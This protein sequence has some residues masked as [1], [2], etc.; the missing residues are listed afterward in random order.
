M[1]ASIEGEASKQVSSDEPAH[2]REHNTRSRDIEQARK[3]LRER[4][5][6][7]V[8]SSKQEIIASKRNNKQTS[9]KQLVDQQQARS[10]P[11][12]TG[13]GYGNSGFRLRLGWISAM[14]TQGPY[15]RAGW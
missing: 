9:M 7:R 13:Y 15:R 4:E 1:Q 3:Q 8:R 10:K 14:G 2:K 6:E 12:T 11:A 5:R